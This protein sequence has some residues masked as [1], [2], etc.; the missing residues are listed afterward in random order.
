MR[1]PR[2]RAQIVAAALAAAAIA[3]LALSF[4]PGAQATKGTPAQ[5]VDADTLLHRGTTSVAL[6]AGAAAALKPLGISVASAKPAHAT[7]SGIPFPITLGVVDSSTLAG[8]IRHA[9]GL[10]LS[11]GPIEVH[12]TR[13]FID[14][15]DTPSLSGR[16]GT[17]PGTGDR[18][19]LFALDLSGLKVDAGRRHIQFSGIA[20]KLTAGAA[21]ALN[22]AFGQGAQPFTRAW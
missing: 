9:G 5:A 16:V 20:L 6:D 21:A 3:A 8:Q 7:K 22:G 10:V 14:I 12:L 4:A 1:L 17:A 13:Y 2:R 15:D 19:D 11:K 18:A